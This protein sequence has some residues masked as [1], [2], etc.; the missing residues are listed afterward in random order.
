MLLF[1]AEAARAAVGNAEIGFQRGAV[2]QQRRAVGGVDDGAALED[3]GAVGRCLSRLP[4]GPMQSEPWQ[5][6][7]VNE[8]DVEDALSRTFATY[9]P[10]STARS[11]EGDACQLL[12]ASKSCFGTFLGRSR[13]MKTSLL[14]RLFQG[15]CGP[16]LDQHMHPL[17]GE[18]PLT[19]L[20]GDDPFIR[21]I[22]TPKHCLTSWISKSGCRA[23]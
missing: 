16:S 20:H 17:D 14:S 9:T 13:P 12:Q 22:S 3:D 21:N 18:A 10:Q 7:T 8:M 4:V 6:S 15:R 1:P 23:A 11:S 5:H 2:A 19:M